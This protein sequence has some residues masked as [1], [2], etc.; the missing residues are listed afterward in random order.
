M[1]VHDEV[2]SPRRD[3][4]AAARGLRQA[5][6]FYVFTIGVALFS[7]LVPGMS[8]LFMFTPALVTLALLMATRDLLRPDI[9]SELGLNRLGLPWWPAAILIP[10]LA[11]VPGYA[12]VWIFGGVDSALST[13]Q[14]NWFYLAIYAAIVLAINTLLFSIAEEIGW[15]GYLLPRVLPLGRIRAHML[16]GLG[17]ALWRYPVILPGLSSADGNALLL[18]TLFTLTLIPLSVVIGEL[19]LRSG[20]LWVASLAHSAHNVAWGILGSLTVGGGNVGYVA[21]ESG[22]IPLLLYTIAALWFVRRVVRARRDRKLQA[23][24]G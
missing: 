5:I 10:V 2:D 1:L 3:T 8:A 11:L 9:W 23:L 7:T 24:A 12:L 19:R 4:P 21:G 16:I 13:S 18:A 6:V 22:I 15:R 14:I 20:S 17:W